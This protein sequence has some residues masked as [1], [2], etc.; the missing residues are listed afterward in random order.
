MHQ[1]KELKKIRKKRKIKVSYIADILGI[2]DTSIYAIEDRE[3]IQLDTLKKYCNALDFPLSYFYPE[4]KEGKSASKNVDVESNS[5][6]HLGNLIKQIRTEKKANVSSF[7]AALGFKNRQSVYS[8]EARAD[9]DFNL[10]KKAA[11]FLEVPVSKLLGKELL[12]T[13][14]IQSE[15][16]VP[17]SI[18]QEK[19]SEIMHLKEKIIELQDE[20]IKLNKLLNNR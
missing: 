4:M 17:A 20:I 16:H 11:D 18:L 5:K 3:L 19:D 7:A 8:M 6:P 15:E 10:V 12:N 1:G 9:I 14:N 13:L 2:K